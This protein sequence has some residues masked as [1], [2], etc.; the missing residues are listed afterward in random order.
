[1]RGVVLGG[2]MGVGKTTVG[3]ALARRTGL[4]FVDTDALITA[5]HGPIARQFQLEGEAVFRARERGV[6]LGLGDGVPRVV[7]VGG[8]VW[9]QP[10][11]GGPQGPLA[12][13]GFRVVLQA[14][15]AWLLPRI[16]GDR[17]RPLADA[18]V[19]DRFARRRR[20]ERDADL[21]LQVD[22]LAAEAVVDQILEAL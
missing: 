6:V 22:A 11:M 9:S 17:S 15:L 18:G 4:P 14:P 13:I 7:A 2:F 21:V 8:G 19:A 16:H 5:R 3:R 10:G 20:F 12:R 1:M